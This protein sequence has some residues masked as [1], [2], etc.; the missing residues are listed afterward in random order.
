MRKAVKTR[1]IPD[2]SRPLAYRN[3]INTLGNY[4]A[5]HTAM[6]GLGE[7]FRNGI[8]YFGTTKHIFFHQRLLKALSKMQDGGIKKCIAKDYKAIIR[9][10]IKNDK[11]P[12]FIQNCLFSLVSIHHN[13]FLIENGLKNL[14]NSEQSAQGSDTTKAK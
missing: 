6:V 14:P 4:K 8:D 9:D 10:R 1:D 13:Q 7:H 2:E 11:L 3:Y 5:G 12:T